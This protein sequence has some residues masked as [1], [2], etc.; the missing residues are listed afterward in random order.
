MKSSRVSA[1]GLSA[2]SN[3]IEKALSGWCHIILSI[4]IKSQHSLSVGLTPLTEGL[5]AAT[6]NTNNPMKNQRTRITYLLL[7]KVRYAELPPTATIVAKI[8]NTS[9]TF[10][11]TG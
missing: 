6:T 2:N 5:Q 4:A 3:N 9:L 7:R 11:K 10:N 1:A 8:S